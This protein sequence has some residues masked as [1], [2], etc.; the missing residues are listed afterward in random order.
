MNVLAQSSVDP[1]GV[2]LNMERGDDTPRKV[3]FKSA[4]LSLII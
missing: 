3:S 2:R 1:S 4:F